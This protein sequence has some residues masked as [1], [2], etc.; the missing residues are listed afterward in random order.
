MVRDEEIVSGR[1]YSNTL[2]FIPVLLY[3]IGKLSQPSSATPKDNT[4]IKIMAFTS[5]Y[6]I[7]ADA[8]KIRVRKRTTRRSTV[9]KAVDL[10]GPTTSRRLH[11]SENEL[12]YRL[13][14]KTT[15]LCNG[16]LLEKT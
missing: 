12:T 10:F 14:E 1:R 15:F 4:R 9:S 11:R 13:K 2:S 3:G 7:N 6:I 5:L 16:R 8:A